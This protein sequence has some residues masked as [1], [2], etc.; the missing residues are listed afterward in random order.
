MATTGWDNLSS[1][2]QKKAGTEQRD[3]GRGV[4]RYPLHPLILLQRFK[5]GL[6]GVFSFYVP[7]PEVNPESLG[8]FSAFVLRSCLLYT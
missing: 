3:R 5:G 4:C 8:R 2:N 6:L 7:H 1:S